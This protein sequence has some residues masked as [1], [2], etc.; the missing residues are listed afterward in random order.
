MDRKLVLVLKTRRAV[1]ALLSVLSMVSALALAYAAFG[2]ESG[3]TPTTALI[4]IFV[5][6]VFPAMTVWAWAWDRSVR[7]RTQARAGRRRLPLLV[8][9]A[10][11]RQLRPTRSEPRATPEVEL[12]EP[13]AHT[14]R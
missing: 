1:F 6:L 10:G 14:Q 4:G 11:G 8:E 12:P 9:H 3:L 13:D 5:L 2:S 7:K